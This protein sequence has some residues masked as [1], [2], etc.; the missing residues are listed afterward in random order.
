MKDFHFTSRQTTTGTNMT[1]RE[2]LKNEVE[3]GAEAA[4]EAEA[5]VDTDAVLIEVEVEAEAEAPAQ[6]GPIK[7]CDQTI[8]QFVSI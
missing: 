3:V 5:P 8:I 6:P 7:R 1:G 4:V 2:G